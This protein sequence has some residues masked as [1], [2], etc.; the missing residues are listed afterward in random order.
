[1]IRTSHIGS[2]PFMNTKDAD[3]FNSFFDLPVLYTLP[4]LDKNQFMLEQVVGEYKSYTEQIL[5]TNISVSNLESIKDFNHF[6]YQMVGPITLIKSLKLNNQ[7]S[8]DD[9][10]NW[11]LKELKD[12]F[13][14]DISKKCYFFLDEPML[15]MATEEEYRLLNNFLSKLEYV[16]NRIGI[17]CC[18]EMKPEW[19]N[20]EFIN[21]ISIESKY[22][23]DLDPSLDFD[24]FLGVLDTKTIELDPIVK[25]EEFKGNVYVTPHCG[26]AFTDI[27]KMGM[28][29]KNLTKWA[30]M[31]QAR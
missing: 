4:I 9:L 2:L 25:F 3:H 12:F 28:V 6:K 11:Y 14:K 23:N 16:F 20:F 21:G 17:H 29:S 18:S 19:L 30:K 8:I 10:L 5:Q 22:I 31:A 7:K 13:S 15:F 24:L 27:E 26:L 1:M